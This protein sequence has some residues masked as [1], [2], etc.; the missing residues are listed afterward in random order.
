M[1]NNASG[2]SSRRTPKT[3]ET[4]TQRPAVNAAAGLPPPAPGGSCAQRRTRN[5]PVSK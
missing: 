5:E 4:T 1:G 2:T 3:G